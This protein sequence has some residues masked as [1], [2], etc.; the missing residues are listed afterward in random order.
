MNVYRLIWVIP[1]LIAGCASQRGIF[2]GSNSETISNL[3]PVVLMSD[4]GNQDDGIAVCKGVML[5]IQPGLTFVD[6]THQ[7]PAFSIKEANRFLANVTPYFPSGTVFVVLVEKSLKKSSRPIVAKSKRGQYFVASDNGALTS[8]A[9]RDGLERV[10]VIEEGKW[11]SPNSLV[12]TFLGRDVYAPVAAHLAR[13]EDWEDIGLEKKDI[14]LLDNKVLKLNGNQLLGEVVAF[15]GPFGNLIT[16]ITAATFLNAHYHLGDRVDV[17]IGNKAMSLPFVRT[18]SDVPVNQSLI[19][20]DSNERVSV[21]IN[22][23]NFAQR[24]K[25]TIPTKFIIFIKKEK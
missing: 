14:N 15:D 19:Y 13:G 3:A 4:F 18:F 10:R 5:K 9:E 2:S 20:I 21:A 12:S 16:D 25:V 7:I 11:V 23:G 24:Y 8:V 6:I 1:L 17:V 22:E